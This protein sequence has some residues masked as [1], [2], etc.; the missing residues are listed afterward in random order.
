MAG[1]FTRTGLA[2]VKHD[3]FQNGAS[4]STTSISL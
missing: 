4:I 2:R 1:C 3:A